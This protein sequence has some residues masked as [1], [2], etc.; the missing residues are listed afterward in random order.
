M[1]NACTSKN[2][3]DNA[4]AEII[5]TE[6]SFAKM[7]LN[8]GIPE[9][10]IA[11]ADSSAVLLRGQKLIRGLDSISVYMKKSNYE[12]VTLEW[13]PYFVDASSSGDLGYTYGDY[14]F[15]IRDSIGQVQSSEGTFHTVWKKQSDGSWKYVW[16]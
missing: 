11:Y 9:A 4:I 2:I 6:H 10:F 13:Q 16:D 15:S 8:V 12:Y 3:R 7:A 5:A 1:V 14:I